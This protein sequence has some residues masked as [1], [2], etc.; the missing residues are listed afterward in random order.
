VLR[1]IAVVAMIFDRWY[2]PTDEELIYH[3]CRAEAFVEIL[4]TRSIWLS[5]S[6]VMND[7]TERSWGYSIFQKAAKALEEETGREFID[8][9]AASVIAGDMHSMLMIGSFSLVQTC[10]QWRAS[11][12]DD[13]HGFAIGFSPKL[14]QRVPAKQLRVLYERGCSNPRVDEQFEARV[15]GGELKWFPI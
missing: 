15:S 8:R 4:R 1:E 3:Y 2:Q 9:I 12:A 6:Y 10:L 13:G 7:I 14:M 11:Y 5:A